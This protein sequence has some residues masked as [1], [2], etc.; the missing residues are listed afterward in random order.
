MIKAQKRFAIKQLHQLGYGK[1]S[2]DLLI[3]EEI[4]LLFK[5]MNHELSLTS[6]RIFEFR[7]TFRSH[8]VKIMWKFLAGTTIDDDVP[9]ILK[10]PYPIKNMALRV[11]LFFLNFFHPIPKPVLRVLPSKLIKFLERD[12]EFFHPINQFIMVINFVSYIVIERLLSV[13]PVFYI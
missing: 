1:S 10:D 11:L 7:R 12:A 4:S 5:Q 2:S 8:T 6:D 3:Q 13:C 9:I